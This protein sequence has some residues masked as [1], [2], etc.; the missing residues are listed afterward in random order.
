MAEPYLSG[1]LIPQQLMI[2]TP[3]WK[4]CH[5][6]LVPG[7]YLQQKKRPGGPREIFLQGKEKRGKK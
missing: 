6:L 1:E 4:G 2:A 7:R 3:P 5:G